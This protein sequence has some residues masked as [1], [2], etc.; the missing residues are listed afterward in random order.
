MNRF[1]IIII[2]GSILSGCSANWHI[3]KAKKKCPDC[4]NLDTTINEVVFKLDTIIKLDTFIWIK[5][6]TDTIKIDSIVFKEIKPSFSKIT[7]KNGII[8]TEVSMLKGELKVKSY[9]E[10]SIYYHY[11]DSVRIKNALIYEL[12]T[13]NIKQG[14]TIQEQENKYNNIVKWLKLIG[15][16]IISMFIIGLLIKWSKWIK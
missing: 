11:K 7:K 12:K 8:T 4:F 16:I 3:Q 9:L 5:L 13:I 1:F 14:I 6:P 15:A 2:L 10:D